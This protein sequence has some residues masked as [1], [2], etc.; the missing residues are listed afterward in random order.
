M[1]QFLRWTFLLL[2]ATASVRG[3]AA[4]EE[5][6]P[7]MK[8]RM[9]DP[10]IDDEGPFCYLS[11]PNNQLG[12]PGAN[13]GA[14]V[15]FDGA[16][17]TGGCEFALFSGNPLT[18]VMVRQ[19]TL[20][21]GWIP[22]LQFSW[23]EGSIE[24]RA[25]MLSET[26]GDDLQADQVFFVRVEAENTS[27]ATAPMTFAAGARFVSDDHR[28]HY[29]KLFP[30]DPE[31]QYEMT[32]NALYRDGKLI[33]AYSPGGTL[34][35]VPGVVYTEPFVGSEYHI[36]DHA[37]AGMVRYN[38]N[39]EAGDVAVFEFK[40]PSLPIAKEETDRIQ[41]LESASYS[42]M[43]NKSIRS[44][45]ERMAEGATVSIPE[46]KV[47]NTFRS[48]IG[49][50][51]Q[52]I[53]TRDGVPTQGVNTFQYRGFWLRDAAYMLHCYDVWG[54]H[55][56]ARMLLD[57][58]DRY[59]R[60]DGLFQSQEGQLDGFGQA[61]YT[62]AQHAFL[63]GD[64]EY[65]RAVYTKFPPSVDWLKKAR[66]EDEFNIMP[67]THTFDNELLKGHYTGHNFWALLGLRGAIRL[68]KMTG[69]TED[70][71]AF[72]EEYAE[73]ESA[74]LDK[75]EEVAGKEGYIPPG[76]D[77]EGGQ[78]WG[79]LIGVFPSEVLSPDDPRIDATLRKVR[80]EKYREGVM[81]Y[82]YGIHHYLTVKAAQNFVYT[83]RQEDA[84]RDFYSILLH[85]GSANEIFEWQAIPWGD[86]DVDQNYP[87][88]GWGESMFNLMLRNMLVREEGGNGGIDGREVHLFSVISPEWAQ[89]GEEIILGNMP[90]ECGP[91]SATY[92]FTEDGAIVEIDPDFRTK[93]L[94]LYLHVPY[95]VSLKGIHSSA[96]AEIEEGRIKLQPTA[97]KIALEWERKE[98]EPLSF[99]YFVERYK[100]EYRKRYETYRQEGGEPVA[101]EAPPL[102]T[103]ERRE[104][105]F[106]N[107][108]GPQELGIAVGKPVTASSP[109]EDEHVPEK[110]VD[111][112]TADKFVSSWWV[113]PPAP[114]W[115]QVDLE[116]PETIDRIHVY[117]FYDGSRFY[118]Y[119]VGVSLDGE[120]WTK[121]IDMS[122]NEEPAASHGD[123]FEF[124]PIEARHVRIT[125]LFNSANTS[126]HL[127]ELK[128][129][130]AE[131]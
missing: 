91:I 69:N 123:R 119:T 63:T 70:A 128:V 120:D 53:W 94:G 100:A 115:L 126:M 40:I 131:D 106:N 62:L 118:Q 44:W 3:P 38:K 51:Q 103:A 27:A 87:P 21:E 116:K 86:R 108:Y 79:N 30:F 17:Y 56:T 99:E 105:E 8:L 129:F 14:Q 49:Y 60:E 88:H 75:L 55:K 36:Y 57:G 29:Y 10:A 39:L 2:L 46:E 23:N 98:T 45:R 111:G 93:P 11:R 77:A 42:E 127:V 24:Y 12:V 47:M 109:S 78:D 16:L 117:P 48:A 85:T 102:L 81:T 84:L 54:F 35:A 80:A 26:I 73:Y 114:Q 4:I 112:N 104:K 121:V 113:G 65:T 7:G 6:P 90:T 50:M 25:E 82:R 59:Q 15:T 61:L 122:E 22:I 20:L 110:A 18:P 92:R 66:A 1:N 97:Q 33:Y 95:F 107:R 41:R 76:L 28:F 71:K 67:G 74:F 125:M 19:K 31:W 96:G 9:V 101:I 64:E 124:D 130:R 13:R 58:Y 52:A 37:V 43:R 89:P 83:G 32:A 34:E 72:A 5:L 68:A